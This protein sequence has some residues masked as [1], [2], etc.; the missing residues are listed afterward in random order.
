MTHWLRAAGYHTRRAG[1]RANVACSEAACARLEARLEGFAEHTGQRVTII[2]QSRGGT[3]A[4]ALAVRRPDLVAG[5]VTLGSPTVSQLRI[6]PLVLAQVGLVSALGSARLP[7]LFSWRCL[8]GDCCEDFRAAVT[9]PF[10]EQVPYVALYSRSDGVVD[11][12]SCLDPAAELV[13]VGTSHCGMGVHTGVYAEIARALPGF[14]SAHGDGTWPR[15]PE[16]QPSARAMAA[17][18]AAS[19][20]STTLPW[21]GASR[22]GSSPRS[23]RALWRAIARSQVAS[24]GAGSGGSASRWSPRRRG[25]STH[26][27]RSACGR[28][29]PGTPRGP[30][31][32]RARRRPPASRRALRPRTSASASSSRRGSCRAACRSRRDRATCRAPAAA[33]RAPRSAPRRPPAARPGRPATRC[34]RWWAW[35]SA[36]RRIGSPMSR[37]ALRIA[38]AERGSIV[39]T[40]V[41]PSSSPTR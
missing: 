24:P 15:P 16:R 29:C 4:R 12:R 37:A 13:E 6:H 19:G 17:S 39:S 36:I 14:G 34:G 32:G 40:S 26:R 22:E 25:S 18:I 9:G 2:G 8:R 21:P 28:A 33:R 27:R 41:R 3:F 31:C 30:G 1:I 5:I 10:P 35:V 23:S 20:A 11:W 7:G 38:L